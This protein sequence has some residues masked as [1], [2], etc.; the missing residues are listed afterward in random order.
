MK[1]IIIGILFGVLFLLP[2][3]FVKAQTSNQDL[4]ADALI[5][6]NLSGLRAQ[7]E[8][9]YDNVSITNSGGGYGGSYKDMCKNSTIK[10]ILS[11]I[12]KDSGKTPK[13]NST[14]DNYAISSPLKSDSSIQ[15]CVDS[16]GFYGSGMAVSRNNI[17]VCEK[18]VETTITVK[19]DSKAQKTKITKM[20]KEKI[21]NGTVTFED[22]VEIEIEIRTL[23]DEKIYEQWRIFMDSPDIET[24]E[25]NKDILIS[26][27]SGKKASATKK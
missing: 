16:T 15:H 11:K 1:K 6:S 3:L 12:K 17:N 22:R 20:I 27:L 9:Y 10:E 4:E 23:H 2:G 18:K 5:K 8:L 19:L 21:N 24:A 14:K 26:M 25:K 13:C 7:A